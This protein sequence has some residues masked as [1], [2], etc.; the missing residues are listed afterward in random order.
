[1]IR[2]VLKMASEPLPKR[3][4]PSPSSIGT[5][6]VIGTHKSVPEL[7]PLLF[8]L[9]PL[10]LLPPV[11]TFTPTKPW[12]FTFSASSP[13]IKHLSSFAHETRSSFQPAIPSSTSGGNTLRKPTVMTTI[14]AP[15]IPPFPHALPNSRPPD[16]FISISGKRSSRTVRG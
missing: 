4:K 2:T 7:L 16:S 5:P 14:S 12:Q 13:I 6:P 10:T 11:D 15:S 9:I 1:M 8:S 3:L